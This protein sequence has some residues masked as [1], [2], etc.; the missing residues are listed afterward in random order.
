MLT[1]AERENICTTYHLH[2][3]EDVPVTVDHDAH[4]DKEAGQE[5]EEDEG[6]IIWV[7]RRP[8]EGTAQLMDLQGVAVPTQQRGPGPGQGV[9][10]DVADGPPRPGEV[11]HLRMDH[12]DVALIGQGNQG[13][14]GNDAWQRRETDN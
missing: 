6:G 8:V 11:H 14:D 5:E 9:E 3:V 7:L 13:H 12:A 4:G 10:P 2:C 1:T